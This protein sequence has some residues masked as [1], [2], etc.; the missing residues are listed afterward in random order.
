MSN[1]KNLIAACINCY[2]ENDVFTIA[3][4]DDSHDPKKFY[5]YRTIRRR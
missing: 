4:G 1:V 2:D 3:I 5:H